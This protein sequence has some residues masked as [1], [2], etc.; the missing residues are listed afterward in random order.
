MATPKKVLS[1]AMTLA[2]AM[3][4]LIAGSCAVDAA[5][6]PIGPTA[7][8][9]TT[10]P[11]AGLLNN[12]A[13]QP[14]ADGIY[15]FTFSLYDAPDGG[16]L[17][18]T[19]VQ[20]DVT[21][22][23][24]SFSAALG[25]ESGLPAAVL[26]RKECWLAVSVRGPSETGFTL[27]EPRQ[28]LQTDGPTAV[29]ALTC[30][31]NH[32]TDYWY[33]SN[34]GYGLE[35]SNSGTGD[36]IRVY[37]GATAYNYAA[38]FAV[39]TASTGY[40]TG[41]YGASAKGVGVYA[42]STS[43]DGLEATTAASGKSAVYAHSTAGNGVYAVSGTGRG[44]FAASTS[45]DGLEAASTAAG[46]SAVYAHSTDGNGV[47]GRSTNGFGMRAGGNDSDISDQL[48]DLYLE[49]GYGE[50]LAGG[51][52]DL[53]SN[54]YIWFDLDQDNNGNVALEVYNGTDNMVFSVGENGNTWASGTKSAL[55]QTA[56]YGPRLLYSLESPEVWF[57]EIGAARLVKGTATV[58]F[59]PIFAETANL[60][61]GY[62]VFV[63]PTCDEPAVLFVSDKTAAGF[64]VQGVT[65]DNQ[66]SSC[67]FDYRVVAKRLGYEDVRLAPVDLDASGRSAR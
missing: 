17:L 24:G 65:L 55:V 48:G 56:D 52:L 57:E 6:P 27:L 39:N 37:S 28:R 7:P 51:H 10:I 35:V 2:L 1:V 3:A 44:V 5:A 16:N 20:T 47:V 63:T 36:G 4:I 60:E 46:K 14:V 23:N 12:A 45:G 49:G 18:W 38:V 32:F 34:S 62:H 50:L 11:Y 21:V 19:G 30:P 42:T 54:N 8:Q 40:G 41:V 53:A 64:T 26:D 9:S 15:A 22:Q 13:G 67:A 31:H 61:T 33:G 43:G 25:G 66:P 29:D 58:A 59:D